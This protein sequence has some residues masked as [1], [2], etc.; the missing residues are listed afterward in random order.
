MEERYLN[1]DEYIKSLDGKYSQEELDEMLEIGHE[2]MRHS[3]VDWREYVTYKRIDVHPD[4]EGE[5]MG[6]PI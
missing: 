4:P 6:R 1:F 2:E 3:N 5:K